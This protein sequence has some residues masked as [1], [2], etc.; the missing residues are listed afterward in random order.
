MQ[1][2]NEFVS[3]SIESYISFKKNILSLLRSF[4]EELGYKDGSITVYDFWLIAIHLRVHQRKRYYEIYHSKEGKVTSMSQIKGIALACFWFLKYKPLVADFKLAEHFCLRN[5]SGINEMFVLF[6]IK[7]F[8]QKRNGDYEK[9]SSFFNE[10]NNE[11][12]LYNFTH[13]DLSKEAFILYV[14]SLVGAIEL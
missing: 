10:R 13:R 9:M 1:N 2:D 11:F 6:L 12:L 4:C 3:P 7:S 14:T 8:V 5:Y